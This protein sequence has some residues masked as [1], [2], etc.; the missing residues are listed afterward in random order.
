MLKG[1]FLPCRTLMR[2]DTRR[3]MDRPKALPLFDSSVDPPRKVMVDMGDYPSILVMPRFD[4]PTIVPPDPKAELWF[5]FLG[6]D[7]SLLTK[8]YRLARWSPAILHRPAY[9]RFLAKIAHAFAT[10]ELGLGSFEPLLL[11]CILGASLSNGSPLIGGCLDKAPGDPS[12][13]HWLRVEPYA[14]G[15]DHYVAVRMRLFAGIDE[16]PEYLIVAGR[17]RAPIQQTASKQVLNTKNIKVAPAAFIGGPVS[18]SIY[19]RRD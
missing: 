16:A 8:K 6:G 4:A 3:P 9:L 15:G 1:T 13:L 18:I 2:L 17:V 14:F 12:C 11:D 10:A 7:I 5:C 19:G